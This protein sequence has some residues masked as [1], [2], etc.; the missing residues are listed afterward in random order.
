MDLAFVNILSVLIPS[1]P[2]TL[3]V[4]IILLAYDIE[5]IFST[6]HIFKYRLRQSDFERE[7]D[8][9]EPQRRGRIP[10]PKGGRE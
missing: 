5:R 3:S 1:H 7:A 9:D 8:E 4:F 10:S 6:R 2:F